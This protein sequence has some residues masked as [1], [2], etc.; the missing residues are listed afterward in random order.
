[1]LYE[2]LRVPRERTWALGVRFGHQT[3]R[4]HRSIVT[5]LVVTC[6]NP[7]VVIQN[8]SILDAFRSSPAMLLGCPSLLLGSP[9]ALLGLPALLLGSLLCSRPLLQ[10]FWLSDK[11]DSRNEI[12]QPGSV[13]QI[14]KAY[15]WLLLHF[16]PASRLSR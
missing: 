1:M 14:P 9:A 6:G 12:L 7:P 3:L 15:L 8:P 4:K 16:L 11:Q 10:P 5:N 2:L 13:L